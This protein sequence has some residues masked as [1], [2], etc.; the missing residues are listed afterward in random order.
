[1]PRAVAETETPDWGLVMIVKDG[2]KDDLVSCLESLRPVVGWWT[3]VDTGSTDG[4]QDKVREVMKGVPGRLYEEPFVNFGSAR[5]RAF[6]HAYGKA[7][8]LIATDADMTW[9]VE[10]GYLPDPGKEAYLVEMGN[11]GVFRWKL[12]LILRG[13]VLWRSVGAVH[14]YTAREDGFGYDTGD[15]HPHITITYPEKA[16][17]EKPLWQLSMLNEEYAKDPDNARTVFYRA[18]CLRETGDLAE[19]RKMYLRRSEMGGYDSEVYYSRFQAATLVPEW[20]ERFVELL[21]VWEYRPHRLEALAVLCRELNSRDQ[22]RTVWK[23]TSELIGADGVIP[24][25]TDV[26]FVHYNCWDWNVPFE[27]SI[28]AWWVGEYAEGRAI[29]ER[30]LADPRLPE[31]LRAATVR[32]LAEFPQVS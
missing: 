16:D 13:D 27:R 28:A 30:L 6:A 10:A 4:T 15:A 32:N 11:N 20:P 24:P 25:T 12:P 18:Q 29:C 9:R 8:W 31:D 17:A 22:H 14:E 7:R 26:G 21:S 5:S 19:S 23:L 3:V 1:M 2:L